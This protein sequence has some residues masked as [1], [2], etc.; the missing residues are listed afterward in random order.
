LAVSSTALY[1]ATP[2]EGWM[3]MTS[4]TAETQLV[5]NRPACA[6]ASTRLSCT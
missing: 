5:S 6:L 3:Y 4:L 1:G 2:P